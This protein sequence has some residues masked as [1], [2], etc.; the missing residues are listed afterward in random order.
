VT[1]FSEFMKRHYSFRWF[2]DTW[3]TKEKWTYVAIYVVLFNI[4]LIPIL[5]IFERTGLLIE[6]SGS[7]LR[8]LALILI[9]WFVIYQPVFN[10]IMTRNDS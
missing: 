3:T 9:L 7:S 2:R 6:G 5:T 1:T 8:V 4:S 10:F